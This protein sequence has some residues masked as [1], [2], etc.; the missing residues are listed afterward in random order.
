[1]ELLHVD[2]EAQ[3]K[4]KQTILVICEMCLPRDTQSYANHLMFRLYYW[5][6]H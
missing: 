6:H 5:K 4:K 3:T 1:V 2:G